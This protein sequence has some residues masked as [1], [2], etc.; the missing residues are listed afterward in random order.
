MSKSFEVPEGAAE[1]PV[2]IV[3]EGSSRLAGRITRS[4]RPLAGAFVNA[5]PD[6]PGAPGE[7]ATAQTDE[8]GRYALEG[9]TDGRY[10]VFVMGQGV[11]YRKPFDVSGDTAGDIELPAVSVSGVVTDAATGEPV[12][13]ASVRAQ[14]GAEASVFMARQGI[15]DS[16]GFY[17]LEDLDAG[18]YRISARKDGYQ[19]KEQ[20]VTVGASSSELNLAMTR[21]AGLAI[22]ATDGHTGLPLRG[23]TVSAFAGPTAAFM[24]SVA[25]DSDGK[26]EISS[27]APG[28]YTLHVFSQGYAPRTVASVAVP[29]GQLAVS[30]TPGGRVEVRSDAPVSGRIVDAAGS[31]Y[32][33]NPFRSDGRVNPAPPLTVWENFAP[34]S[35]QLLVSSS[36]GE[37]SYPFT[38]VEGRTTALEVR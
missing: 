36:S 20:T 26:G 14:T 21:G 9:L 4:D 1:L 32:L 37:K 33:L 22:R 10:Q 35:Y 34:G 19:L 18:P 30:L 27:L 7:R 11:S 25:L 6:P 12:E 31:T 23:L 28:T 5:S 15:T 29:S 13:G 38:V 16:R 3:F 17:S 2:E 8:D 24:G